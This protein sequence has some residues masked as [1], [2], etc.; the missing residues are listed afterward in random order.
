MDSLLHQGPVLETVE[1][2]PIAPSVLA[3][4]WGC[5]R[6]DK[7]QRELIDLCLGQ[8]TQGRF[9]IG[10]HVLIVVVGKKD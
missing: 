6:R 3:Q 2:D 7:G 1:V 5:G 9:F 10:G 8:E 4:S